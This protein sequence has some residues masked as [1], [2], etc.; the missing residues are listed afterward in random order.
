M[1]TK[2]LIIAIAV[3]AIIII[4]AA[5]LFGLV[6]GSKTRDKQ[7]PQVVYRNQSKLTFSQQ[8]EILTILREKGK[9]AAIKKYRVLTGLGLKDTKEAIEQLERNN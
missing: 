5:F 9:I 2:I 4:I 8:Q 3:T 7:T 1:D 6:I